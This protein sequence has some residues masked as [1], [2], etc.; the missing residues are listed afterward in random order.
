MWVHLNHTL[1]V[2]LQEGE[3]H[4]KSRPLQKLAQLTE[5]KNIFFSYSLKPEN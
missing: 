3:A 4:L 2:T 5:S 1:I